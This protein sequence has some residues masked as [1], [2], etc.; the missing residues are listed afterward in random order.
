MKT[1]PRLATGRPIL[2]RS[3]DVRHCGGRIYPPSYEDRWLELHVS[4]SYTCCNSATRPF[5]RVSETFVARCCATHNS[6][7][8]AAFLPTGP[9]AP[10][11]T[12][13]R[14]NATPPGNR[15]RRTAGK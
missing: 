11:T 14:P 8:K 1:W 6:A 10:E 13:I 5:P 3:S 4:S 12:P 2:I 15:G 9:D 7:T